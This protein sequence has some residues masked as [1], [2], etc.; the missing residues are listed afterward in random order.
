MLKSKVVFILISFCSAVAF[1]NE[2]RTT[3]ANATNTISGQ[4]AS[5]L[6]APS[7][8][9]TVNEGAKKSKSSALIGMAANLGIAAAMYAICPPT[10][11]WACALG[12]MA[13]NQ[14]GKSGDTAAGAG[15]S[16]SRSGGNL[17]TYA[18]NGMYVDPLTGASVPFAELSAEDRTAIGQQQEY[19]DLRNKFSQMGYTANADGSVTTP[20]GKIIPPSA[21]ASPSAMAAAGF[22]PADIDAAGAAMKA[23]NAAAAD[24]ARVVAAQMEE[25]GGGGGSESGGGRGGR[26]PA[27]AGPDWSKMFGQQNAAEKANNVNPKILDSSGQPLIGKNGCL[28]CAITAAYDRE[29]AAGSLIAPSTAAA[30]PAKALMGRRPSSIPGR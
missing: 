27:S 13:M 10:N 16:A 1:G 17:P 26:S 15:N 22:S 29:E 9:S 14:A 20:N 7:G 4:A 28:F 19:N 23:A 18:G 2:A 6:Q 8:G 12:A 30:A 24:K 21:F 3:A 11:A 25:G 5:Q